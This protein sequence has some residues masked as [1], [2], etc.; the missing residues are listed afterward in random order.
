MNNQLLLTSSANNGPLKANA[1]SQSVSPDT[2]RAQFEAIC[3]DESRL[4]I[5]WDSATGKIVHASSIRSPSPPLPVFESDA[6][7]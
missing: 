4:N 5:F 6:Q 3:R 1:Q 7:S 2:L